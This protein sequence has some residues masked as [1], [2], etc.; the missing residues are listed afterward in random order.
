MLT[1]VHIGV[2]R[3]A[4]AS[5]H[6]TVHTTAYT[7][8]YTTVHMGMMADVYTTVDAYPQD[9]THHNFTQDYPPT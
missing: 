6:R 5:V 7:A 4:H 3:T 8:V 9:C 1:T 2:Q